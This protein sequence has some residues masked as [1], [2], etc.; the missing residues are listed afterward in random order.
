MC[1]P[2]MEP[3]LSVA[4]NMEVTLLALRVFVAEIQGETSAGGKKQLGLPGHRRRR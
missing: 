2:A 1:S 3:P 4:E